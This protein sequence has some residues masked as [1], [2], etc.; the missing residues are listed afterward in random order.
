MLYEGVTL[1][2]NE[3]SF[4]IMYHP[5]ITI[6]HIISLKQE[7]S[8]DHT[9]SS[10]IFFFLYEALFNPYIRLASLV[11]HLKAQFY[12]LSKF[13]NI[14]FNKKYVYYPWHGKISLLQL[15]FA[16]HWLR[17]LIHYVPS[18]LNDSFKFLLRGTSA[19]MKAACVNTV[20]L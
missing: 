17:Y 10:G 12:C 20:L 4:S 3:F 6:M 13:L 8:K 9:H 18:E 15:N 7:A 5:Y 2:N 11:L 14:D 16:S 19:V 1:N